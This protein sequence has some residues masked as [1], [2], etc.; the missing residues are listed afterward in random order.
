M[1]LSVFKS[2]IHKDL[3][4][5]RHLVV[6]YSIC[7]VVA[8]ALMGVGS[9]ALSFF[10]A[11]VLFTS[12]IAL[13]CHV[14]MRSIIYE[15]KEKNIRFLMTLPVTPFHVAMCKM[16]AN[17]LVFLCVASIHL[18]VLLLLFSLRDH[19]PAALMA[20]YFTAYLVILAGFCIF[21]AV[22][23]VVE[24]EGVSIVCMIVNNMFLAM[25][26]IWSPK[27]KPVQ[28]ALASGSIAEL[29]FIWPTEMV[30]WMCFATL[31]G[32]VLLAAALFIRAHNR[33]F[34]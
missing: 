26:L 28:D 32:L 33:E 15:K 11:V 30:M 5:Y 24:S 25:F 14:T 1:N 4:L 12:L 34:L 31:T 19:L 3:Q 22:A 7:G 2:L 8:V 29:G 23:L 20:Y 21:L 6:N 18:L 13:G 9:E 10:A 17:V 27:H 16:V